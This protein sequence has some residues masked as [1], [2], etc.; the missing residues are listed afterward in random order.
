MGVVEVCAI[1]GTDVEGSL[2][3]S[4]GNRVI[5]RRGDPRQWDMAGGEGA[6]ATAC[7]LVP[8][9]GSL[10]V[11]SRAPYR[12]RT[13]MRF[14]AYQGLFFFVALFTLW[15]AM[16]L[17]MALAGEIPILGLLLGAFGVAGWI[18]FLMGAAI[19]W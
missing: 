4:C 13:G 10:F 8:V 6:I 14:H 3:P 12:D 9:L 15:L 17:V 5:P 19:L 7:Y 1:C 16:E 18:M 2:C 11:M